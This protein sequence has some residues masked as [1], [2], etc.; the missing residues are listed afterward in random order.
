AAA[1]LDR[2]LAVRR[3][4]ARMEPTGQAPSA[5][6]V[7]EPGHG[8]RLSGRLNTRVRT[9]G[10]SQVAP[11]GRDQDVMSPRRRPRRPLSTFASGTLI[12]L[13]G[14]VLAAMPAQAATLLYSDDFES[15]AVA[16]APAGWNATSGT[17]VVA[18]DGTQVM[19]E[20]DTN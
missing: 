13:L 15:D 14:A 5:P 20:T 8:R 10:L 18:V 12:G 9:A 4:A 2:H 1:A 6:P 17:W 16:S 11:G 7:H 3:R 19:K